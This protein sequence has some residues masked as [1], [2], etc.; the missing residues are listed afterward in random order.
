MIAPNWSVTLSAVLLSLSLSL[1]FV[2]YVCIRKLCRDSSIWVGK[3]TAQQLII[4]LQNRK[5]SI[6]KKYAF[7]CCVRAYKQRDKFDFVSPR[8]SHSSGLPH[9]QIAETSKMHLI[10]M[11]TAAVKTT[12][13]KLNEPETAFKTFE[14]I[15][16]NDTQVNQKYKFIPSYLSLALSVSVHPF[17]SINLF[18]FI[19]LASVVLFD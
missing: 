7:T 4:L 12:T 16:T 14:T 8:P 1:Y 17:L 6:Q 2:C 9:I 11:L 15:V 19:T 3:N 13:R 5:P 10:L 18:D